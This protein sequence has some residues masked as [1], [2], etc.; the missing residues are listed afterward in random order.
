M[1]HCAPINFA[2]ALKFRV[3]IVID[4]MRRA[5]RVAICLAARDCSVPD[6][7]SG[8]WQNPAGVCR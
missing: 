2:A 3:H 8:E 6:Q 5:S 1:S 4:V 7:R